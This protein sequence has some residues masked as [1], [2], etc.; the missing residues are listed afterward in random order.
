MWTLEK[1][2]ILQ[3]TSKL[4]Q[5]KVRT[6]SSMIIG[7]ETTSQGQVPAYVPHLPHSDLEIDLL[8]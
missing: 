5:L 6:S 7:V 8:T 4:R 2:S 1:R 3:H